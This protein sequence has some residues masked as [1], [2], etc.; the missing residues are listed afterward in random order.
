MSDIQ[1]T[2]IQEVELETEGFESKQSIVNNHPTQKSH[3]GKMQRNQT[4]TILHT[5]DKYLDS[6][7]YNSGLNENKAT[8][9][10]FDRKTRNMF[11]HRMHPI[12]SPVRLFVLQKLG[13][14][15]MICTF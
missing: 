2:M 15:R 3:Y 1:K 6:I 13:Q 9:R 5:T 12:W 4:C 8:R 11:P 14:V 10:P 7:G